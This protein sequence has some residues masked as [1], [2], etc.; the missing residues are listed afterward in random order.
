MNKKFLRMS[1]IGLLAVLMPFSFTACEDYDDDIN[2]VNLKTD[3]LSSQ[4]TTLESALKD[5]QAA[6][7]GAQKTADAAVAAAAD[8]KAA[9]AAAQATGD[10]A[11]AAAAD[12]AAAAAEA[13]AE[14][15][16][17]IAAAETAKAEAIEAAMAQVKEMLKGYA[18]ASDLATLAGTVEGIQK[19]LNTLTNDLKALDEEV[20][21]NARAITA[22]ET[23]I[24]ALEKFEEATNKDLSSIKDEL[25]SIKNDITG[26][27]NELN[28]KM[29]EEDV[30]KLLNSARTEI[31]KE[32]SEAVAGSKEEITEAYTSAIATAISTLKNVISN[33]LTSV[34]LVPELYVGGIET[35][36]FVSLKYTPKKQGA[37]GLV[38]A[39]A[40]VIVSSEENPAYYRLN[41]ITT[42]ITDI[43][44]DNI[45]FVAC[46]AATR[47][48]N[49]A[50]KSP[51]AYVV[52]SAEIA[53]SGVQKGILT[54][55]AKKTITTSLELGN[56]Q[57]YTVALK[58]PVAS[59]LLA[60]EN[61]PEYVYSEYARLAETTVTPE[62]AALPY[63]CKVA[64]HKHY[65]DSVTIWA[66]KVDAN[67]LVS[68]TWYYKDGFDVAN[69]V[70]GCAKETGKELS[71]EEL[72]K[73]GLEFRYAIPTK[74][75][76]TGTEHGTDQQQFAY[77]EG[78]VVKSKTPQGDTQNKAVIDKE[79]II[80]VTLW[81]TVNNKM[82]DQRYIK[83]KWADKVLPD[84]NLGTYEK[85]IYVD[86][87][88]APGIFLTWE[89]FIKF[90]AKIEG[91]KLDMSKDQFTKVYLSNEPLT[92]YTPASLANTASK[93]VFDSQVSADA[94]VLSWDMQ[95][96]DIGN[97]VKLNTSATPHSWSY[98][99]NVFTADITFVPN[100]NDYP[101][102]ILKLVQTVEFAGALPEINGYYEN[103][104]TTVKEEYPVYPV[105][106][107]TPLQQQLGNTTCVFHNNLMNGF[108][109][110]KGGFI[111]K[112]LKETCRTWDMQFCKDNQVS[113]YA[114]VYTGNE[115]DINKEEN[116]EG[117]NL[118]KGGNVAA[119][120][121]WPDGH[122][123]WCKNIDHKEAIIELYDKALINKTAHIGVWATVNDYNLIPVTDYK[124]RFIEPLNI[125]TASIEDEFIDGVI[126]GSRIDW[127]KTFKMYDCFGYTVAKVTPDLTDLTG[128]VLE[129]T[130]YAAELYTY[131]GVTDPA[132]DTENIKFGM[133]KDSNGNIVVDDTKR[134]TK[135]D[136]AA[137]TTG[138]AIPSL[139]VSG[140]ELVFHSNLGSQVQGSFYIW[141][142]VTVTYEWGTVTTEI[143]VKVNTM[144]NTPIGG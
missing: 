18:S 132:W 45:E 43:D 99:N 48:A 63:K 135:S 47:G 128:E 126:S 20:N 140:D 107:G 15:Q 138:G 136:L 23:Q 67:E 114:P 72:A 58:V 102:L 82:V 49:H 32:I 78:S 42:D 100:N 21:Q 87:D 19:G 86:C 50:I 77:I 124:V 29:T 55:R 125:K 141:I 37:N 122:T 28:T 70:T 68:F 62:I 66:S 26:I 96:S 91:D 116:I 73:Y 71:K 61:V 119:K 143:K 115:P 25:T 144:N 106:Y 10:A 81:D 113:G 7:D 41:P 13:K 120:L 64:T 139:T 92:A 9:A 111:V 104:W 123:A 46:K 56:N 44:A 57:A 6:I 80:R 22:I 83:I 1:L 105:Q 142:P 84:V 93:V 52:G 16:K 117:Y 65:S 89:E 17:A 121:V 129:K 98:T 90:Y 5:A 51:V 53:S 94:A 109:F 34:T 59:H 60:D 75:Y 33:R 36:E 112:N 8:A 134:M 30:N 110:E 131:Y 97:I 137:I 35:I 27:K 79:P 12:A 101:R 118:K 127:T 108:T 2:A 3:G 14:A 103:Y 69:Y 54:V 95:A 130:Q 74:A 39:G 24:A 11:A 88:D 40:D 31:T 38:S 4:L 133:K 76:T 85:T